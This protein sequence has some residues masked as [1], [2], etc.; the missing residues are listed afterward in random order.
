MPAGTGKENNRGDDMRD[1]E[2]L[3]GL[4]LVLAI[5]WI[6]QATASCRELLSVRWSSL[7]AIKTR[8]PD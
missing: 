1:D 8:W 4:L 7:P 5:G 3:G 2:K 6:Y